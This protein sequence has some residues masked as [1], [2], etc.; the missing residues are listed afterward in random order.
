MRPL[1]L[2]VLRCDQP[3]KSRIGRVTCLETSV[4]VISAGAFFEVAKFRVLLLFLLSA[5]L[6]DALDEAQHAQHC[7]TAAMFTGGA[8]AVGINVDLSD[9]A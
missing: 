6:A 8:W 9:K 7:V 4:I 3:C 2:V 1:L 5:L